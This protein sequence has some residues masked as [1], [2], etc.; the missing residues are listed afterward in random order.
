M[1]ISLKISLLFTVLGLFGCSTKS[2][3]IKIG[4]NQYLASSHGGVETSGSIVKV[5][6]FK[7]AEVFCQS[8]GQKV[9]VL[10]STHKDNFIGSPTSA[11]IQFSCIN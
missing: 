3:V 7:E 4:E 10:S 5:G 1:R 8:K 6:L 2:G 9:N 11:E